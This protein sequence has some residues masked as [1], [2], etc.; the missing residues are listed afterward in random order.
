MPQILPA[1]FHGIDGHAHVFERDLQLAEGR[2]YAPTY[3]ATLTDYLAQLDSCGLSHGV[4][5]QP[6]FLGTDNRYLLAALTA[7]PERLRG[8]VVVDRE[9]ATSTLEHMAAAGVKGV[10]L[11]LM[12]Q[13]MD[14][15]ASREWQAFFSRLAELGL[16]V[17]LHRQVEDLPGVLQSLLRTGC[18][19]VIDH[20]GRADARLGLEQPGFARMLELGRE[21]DVWVKVS[22][23]Y[24]LGG[25]AAEQHQF[26]QQALPALCETL[27]AERLLWGSDWPHTQ[28]EQQT[29]FGEQWQTIRG[30]ISDTRLQTQL[31]RDSAATLFG[32]NL[33]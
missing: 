28:H 18:Q 2:R 15:F 20:F 1:N 32:I 9:V 21:G 5:V 6:S 30:L 3:D 8:V 27:G 25:S 29:S 10:R 13:A 31:L 24:R 17:E 22:A 26:A 4:L 14:D 19:V 23:L 7:A 12:G 33:S 11:N 16:H